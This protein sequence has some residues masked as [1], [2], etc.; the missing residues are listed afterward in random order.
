MTAENR[1]TH[2]S[3]EN[4]INPLI[5][6][7]FYKKYLSNLE[8]IGQYARDLESQGIEPGEIAQTVKNQI[9][10]QCRGVEVTV[11]AAHSDVIVFLRNEPV[12][13]Y[14]DWSAFKDEKVVVLD[15]QSKPEQEPSIIDTFG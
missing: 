1:E 7:I 13:V 6:I 11:D 14:C 2:F 9:N 4:V 15:E 10:E 3:F 5:Q 8:E 12:V